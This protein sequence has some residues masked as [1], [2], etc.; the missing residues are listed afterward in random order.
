MLQLETIY[1]LMCGLVILHDKGGTVSVSLIEELSCEC[2]ELAL[3]SRELDACVLHKSSQ[4]GWL[5]PLG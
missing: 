5:I 1:D 2:L 4:V 3:D